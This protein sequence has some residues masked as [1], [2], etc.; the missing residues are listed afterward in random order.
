MRHYLL[1]DQIKAR[2]DIHYV[3]RDE[4]KYFATVEWM[5][6]HEGC[7]YIRS[8]STWF[9]SVYQGDMDAGNRPWGRGTIVFDRTC[10]TEGFFIHGRPE[11][12]C[13]D[14]H[15]NGKLFFEGTYRDGQMWGRGKKYWDTG[16]RH[17]EGEFK[18]GEYHGEGK[19]YNEDGTLFYSGQWRNGRKHG[20]TLY[21][22]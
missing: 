12:K 20:G 3:A 16:N 2:Y 18:A 22:P 15:G 19:E 14:Y 9:P 1:L 11:Y 13:R 4:A 6:Y 7:W 10:R 21:Y 17:Y 8:R 5:E